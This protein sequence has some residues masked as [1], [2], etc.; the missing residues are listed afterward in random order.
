[1]STTKNPQRTDNH[2][3]SKGAKILSKFTKPSCFRVYQKEALPTEGTP[4]RL[5]GN[6]GSF[7]IHKPFVLS[8]LRRKALNRSTNHEGFSQSLRAFVSIKK[9]P[10]QRTEHHEGSKERRF[11]PKFH[12]TPSCFRVYDEKPS[13]D[14]QNHEGSKGAK[15]L[16]K[17][18]K[19]S[20]FRVYDE[21]PSTDRQTTKASKGAKVLPK[22]TNPSCRV[23]DEKPSTDRQPRRLEGTK[24]LFES[25]DLRVF[26]TGTRGR[27]SRVQF[28]DH[29]AFIPNATPRRLEGTKILFE[30]TDLRVFVTGRRPGEL[31][32]VQPIT[33]PSY[34]DTTQ[35]HEGSKERRFLSN[36]H[37][38]FA[39]S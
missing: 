27:G 26:V 3:G 17:F 31:R 35:H 6:E 5:E 2:E 29:A 15:I 39:F 1:V 9:K 25:T 8:C 4:R 38:T 30:S 34:P 32:P 22:F 18:T 20:S 19:P 11:F 28:S 24:I 14:R 33:L 23:Y 37:R 13:T 10:Y 36:P 7:Q 12:K 21:K 16:S